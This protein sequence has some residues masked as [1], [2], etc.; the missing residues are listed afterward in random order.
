MV[1]LAMQVMCPH[2]YTMLLNKNNHKLMAGRHKSTITIDSVVINLRNLAI[3]LLGI[4]M[5]PL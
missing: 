2:R 4:A 3:E 1:R 5:L